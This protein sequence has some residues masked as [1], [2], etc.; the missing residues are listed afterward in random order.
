MPKRK[1]KEDKPRKKLGRKQILLPP[2]AAGAA[3][4]IGLL[5]MHFIPTPSVLGI[6]LR[7]GSIDSFNVY[8]RVQIFVDK[9]MR[10]LP[11][12]VGKNPKNGGE[13]VRVI[14]TDK[15]GNVIHIQ[16]VRP[17]RLTMADFM[18]IYSYDNKTI[19]VIDNSTG[20]PKREVLIL[21]N[22]D[23]QYSYFSERGE[24]TKVLNL[25]SIPPF[26]NNMVARIE[27]ISK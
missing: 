21:D 22:Y 23:I 5:I 7:P 18:K 15:I 13:C 14:H 25:P 20:S 1:V 24:F 3:T 16:Y 9:H 19:T 8:P 4:L 27:L 10:L 11:D 26:T 12:D 2:V 6:C 17:I